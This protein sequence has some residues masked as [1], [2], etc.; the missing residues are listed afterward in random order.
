MYSLVWARQPSR[1]H[2]QNPHTPLLFLC[3]VLLATTLCVYCPTCCQPTH[4]EDSAPC[5]LPPRLSK[6]AIEP[7]SMSWWWYVRIL[8]RSTCFIWSHPL[9]LP[10][11]PVL[12]KH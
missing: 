1:R 2:C 10:I 12:S 3:C 7:I 11:I 6:G 4:A 5:H 8:H 9:F